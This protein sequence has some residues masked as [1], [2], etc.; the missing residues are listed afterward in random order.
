VK[1]KK[2][3]RLSNKT[4]VEKSRSSKEAAMR[5]GMIGV[6]NEKSY[7]RKPPVASW[8]LSSDQKF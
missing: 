7:Y 3:N 8:I 2:R 6:G 1:K 4:L 5:K